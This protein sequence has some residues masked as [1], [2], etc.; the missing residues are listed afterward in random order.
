MRS[1]RTRDTAIRLSSSRSRTLDAFRGSAGPV[2]LPIEAGGGRLLLVHEVAFHNLRYYLHRFLRVDDEWRCTSVS[3][4]FYFRHLGI[5]FACGACLAHGGDVLITF[6]SKIARR[7]CAVCRSRP[8]AGS[9]G[10]CPTG[11][12]ARRPGRGGE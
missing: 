3:R 1:T 10:R 9:C 2:D 11:R 12:R 6:G 4:P 5:E 8:C 7:G